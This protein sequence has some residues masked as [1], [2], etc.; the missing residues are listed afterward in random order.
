MSEHTKEPSRFGLII[1]K[2]NNSGKIESVCGFGVRDD[3]DY[4]SL[5]DYRTIEAQLE[6]ERIRLA[7]CGVVALSN[8]P[9]SA[10]RAREMLP[11]YESASCNDVARMVDKN[12]DLEA[13]LAE[14]RDV[15]SSIGYPLTIK[16]T[17]G[18][19]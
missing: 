1:G 3:G 12:M 6:R 19:R 8:T 2:V 14:L 7:A 18:E 11:E 9:E 5:S 10:A 15:L 17:T 4:V 13:Q 16:N